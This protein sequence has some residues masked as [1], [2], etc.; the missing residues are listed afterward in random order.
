MI[1]KGSCHCKATR[2]EVA[3]APETVFFCTCSFCSKRGALWAYYNPDEVTFTS[4]E[5]NAVYQWQ[6][7]TV[8][9]NFCA[10]CGCG[11]HLQ[12]P[13]FSTGVPDFD[14]PRVGINARL[15]DDFALD[16]VPVTVM[17]GRNDWAVIPPPARGI[18]R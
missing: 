6:S 7:R 4:N 9:H 10:V 2:F 18:A 1:V 15:L 13:D 14:H 16:E 8:K 12:S 5:D 3:S 11:T 17:D